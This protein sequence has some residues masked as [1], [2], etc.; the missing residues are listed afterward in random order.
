M[1]F[2]CYSLY[3]ATDRL[4]LFHISVFLKLDIFLL[5]FYLTNSTKFG[6]IIYI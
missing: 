6:L 4:I 5:Y 3:M 1:P 2:F